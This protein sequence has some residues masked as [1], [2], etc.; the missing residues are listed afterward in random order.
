MKFYGTRG[1]GIA[2]V[3]AVVLSAGATNAWAEEPI[4]VTDAAT[5]IAAVAPGLVNATAENSSVTVDDPSSDAPTVNVP[6]SQDGI[7]GDDSATSHGVSFS[8]DY[9]GAVLSSDDGITVLQAKDGDVAAYV[10]PIASGVRVVTA[11]ANAT[12]PSSYDYT[13]NVPSNTKLVAGLDRFYLESGD[14]NYGSLQ[15]PW[16][17][18][19]A[20]QNIPT[21]YSWYGSTLTQHV[22]LS[23]TTIEFPVLADPAWGYTYTYSQKWSGTKNWRLLHD[24]FNCYFPVAG[25][26]RA[27]PS[28]GAD[29]PLRVGPANFHCKMA[30]TFT[31][32]SSGYYGWQFNAA[33]GHVDGMGSNI[34]FE[35]KNL[36]GPGNFKLYVSAYIVNDDAWLKNPAYQEGARLNW[37]NFSK[38][39]N[40]AA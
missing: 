37:S 26:P 13:F 19:A 34:V 32:S 27:F 30:Q 33:S 3:L 25:A 24:C 15:L 17:Q 16:A 14:T 29:L 38:N 40:N 6:S 31:D 10:Q 20:G 28:Y 12:A 9:T 11:I 23:S 1:L 35:F 4:D 36:A 7:A 22:D 2:A 8:V 18:D 21:S 39:L 5:T